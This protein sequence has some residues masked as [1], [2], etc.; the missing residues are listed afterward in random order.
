MQYK[1]AEP[2]RFALQTPLAGFFTISSLNGIGGKSK[3]GEIEVLDISPNGLRFKSG[4]ELPVDENIEL[5]VSFKLNQ[6]ML[7]LPGTL[8]WSKVY[9][10]K[11]LYGFSVSGTSVFKDEIKQVIIKELKQFIKNQH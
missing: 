11:W 2:F 5:I 6:T 1:R 7:S 9:F 3:K 10:G 8:V 4:L